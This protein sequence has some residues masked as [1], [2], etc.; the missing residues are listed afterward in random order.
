MSLREGNDDAATFRTRIPLPTRKPASALAA[1]TANVVTSTTTRAT[2]GDVKSALAAAKRPSRAN[3][4]ND[5]GAD[6]RGRAVSRRGPG[7][8]SSASSAAP[9]DASA[10]SSRPVAPTVVTHR[11]S[12]GVTNSTSSENEHD[13]V[14]VVAETLR[15]LDPEYE[16][17]LGARLAANASAKYDFK[18]QIAAAKAFYPKAKTLLKTFRGVIVDIAG[19]VE[20]AK[21]A[22][23]DTVL[24][25]VVAAEDAARDR[26]EVAAAL[27]AARAEAMAAAKAA[28]EANG[29]VTETKAALASAETKTLTLEQTLSSVTTELE[30]VRAEHVEAS[31]RA[32]RLETALEEQTARVAELTAAA[33]PAKAQIESLLAEK[34]VSHEQM[35]TLKGELTSA[36]VQLESLRECVK[37]HED[38]KR[39]ES[40]KANRTFAD[41]ARVSA[42]RDGVVEQLATAREEAAS[43]RAAAAEASVA[44]AESKARALRLEDAAEHAASDL[45][46]ARSER[47][48]TAKKL[49]ETNAELARVSS[50]LAAA[51]ARAES[52]ER[53]AFTL[54]THSKKETARLSD[55]IETLKAHRASLEPRV[56]TLCAE[57]AEARADAKVARAE[58]EYLRAAGDEARDRGANSDA[59]RV[60]AEAHALELKD[61]TRELERKT[62]EAESRVEVLRSKLDASTKKIERLE[63]DAEEEATKRAAF[64]KDAS[65]ASSLRSR[66]EA[67]RVTHEEQSSALAAA[68]RELS[69]TAAGAAAFSSRA[70]EKERSAEELEARCAKL[71][72]LVHAKDFEIRQNAIVRRALHNQVQELKGNIRVFC[73]VRPVNANAGENVDAATTGGGKD[74]AEPLLKVARAGESAG[75]ALSVAQPGKKEKP[76]NF[77]F[78]RVFDA[79]ASQEEVFEDISHLVTSS[80]D[81]YKVCIFAYGQTGS[82]K[83]YTMLGDG[84]A[85]DDEHR[86]LIPRCV[87]Q[88]FLAR[89]AD[90][91]TSRRAAFA[92]TATM[93]EIYNE[94]IKDLLA[95]VSSSKTSSSD[96]DQHVKHDVKHDPKTGDTT[97]THLNAVT[98][99]SAAHASS[100]VSKAIAARTTHKTKMNDHSSRSH[101]VFTLKLTGTDTSGGPLNGVLNLVDLAGS[102][103]LSR[104]GAT[105]DRLKEAQNINKSLSALGDVIAALAE[106]APHVPYRNS[107]LTYLLQ[108]ALGGDAKTLMF[109]N[110]APVA[111]SAQETLCSL[112]FAAKVNACAVG[113]NK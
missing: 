7:G 52:A 16:E 29:R 103:R 60:A 35:G 58:S 40:E 8:V 80:L 42:E 11:A 108:N 47:D 6:A 98:V 30:R 37:E 9:N 56:E 83:T 97:V 19:A 45:A 89:D 99:D 71:E 38:E 70:E 68:R 90:G 72:A 20:D 2:A 33:E 34:S 21:K 77:A 32:A 57:L 15:Q 22:S 59:E 112:R 55:E 54:E 13:S 100:L 86:G 105:G 88:I 24:E 49:D 50:R 102:E 78:D 93:V 65:E 18:A 4:E 79:S 44:V 28:A 113:G 46:R 75:R 69:E 63:R 25:A 104:T 101:M 48:A 51:E 95:P 94:E 1:A 85:N 66:L 76:V 82:G 87:E 74:H 111:E 36:N 84:K 26:D 73:R 62:S 14:V 106:K 12:D 5:A 107:K 110:V 53:E 3:K 91:S 23:A 31:E 27:A 39:R 61:L 109:A 81:G 67:L 43:A 96:T 41:L 92:V 10:P 64:E 17:V